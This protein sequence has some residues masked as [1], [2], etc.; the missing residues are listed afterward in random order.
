MAGMVEKVYAD[1]VFSLG[2]DENCLD[3]LCEEIFGLADIFSANEELVKLLSAPTVSL[4]EKTAVLKNIF[5]GKISEYAMNFILVLTEK[6]RAA[7]LPKIAEQVK[8]EYNERNGILE[9]K[10]T[11]SIPMKSEVKDKL[12]RKL[13]AVTGKKITL[14][15]RVDKSILGGIV[16]DYGNTRMDSSV[17]SRLDGMHAQ[18]KSII[19]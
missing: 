6:N 1:A 11:T 14:V 4:D 12:V 18:I 13:E 3:T 5:G 2:T 16:L 10:A 9:V 15:E 19:A 17:K 8:N 7:Y